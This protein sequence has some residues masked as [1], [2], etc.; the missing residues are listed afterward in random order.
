MNEKIRCIL[1][2]VVVLLC[3][4]L[5]E[6]QVCGVSNVTLSKL[7]DESTL[8]VEG[9]VTEQSCFWN[10]EKNNIYTKYTIEVTQAS[11]LSAKKIYVIAEGG[12]VNDINI[13]VFGLPS[14]ALQSE[15]VFFLNIDKGLIVNK[16]DEIYYSIYDVAFYDVATNTIQN[17]SDILTVENFNKLLVKMNNTTFSFKE[18]N[19]KQYKAAEATITDISPKVVGAGSNKL[20]TITGNDFGSLTGSAKIS[21]RSAASLNAND[22]IDIDKTN[23]KSWANNKIQFEVPGD[24]ITFNFPGVASGKIRL[25]NSVG[26]VTTSSQTV[27]VSYNRKLFRGKPV[28]VRSKNN[29][30]EILFYVERKLIDEGALP[31]IEN[32]FEIWNCAI[33]SSFVYA[34]VVDNVCKQY[35]ETNVICYDATVPTFNLAITKVVSRNCSATN[36]ADQIDADI[37]FNPNLSWGFNDDLESSQFHFESVLIHE[38]GHAFMLSHV[39]NNED[40]MYPRLRNGLIKVDL[41]QNDVNGGLDVLASSTSTINCSTYGTIM[42]YVNGACSGCSNVANVKAKNLTENSAYIT[43]DF[44]RNATSYNLGYRFGGSNWYNYK[45]KHNSLI[46]YNLPAC[47]TVECRLSAFCS[48][49]ENSEKEVTYRFITFGCQ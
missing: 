34:G 36:V 37:T 35:D 29:A 31:A 23:I 4:N 1:F 13:K 8:I 12:T 20:L 41:T 10:D 19:N 27:E 42:P 46:L 24:E 43:W 32:A 47:T 18:K 17:N 7:I 44:I 21:M 38:M 14:L 40:V 33:G 2:T 39:V 49:D 15:G 28:R 6:A 22:F 48:N 25:T 45:G 9:K 11:K 5:I 30:G 3:V 26:S 16:T